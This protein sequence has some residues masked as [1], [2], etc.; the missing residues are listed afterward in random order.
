MLGALASCRVR[1]EGILREF[2][3]TTKPCTRTLS[4]DAGSLRLLRIAASTGMIA[5]REGGGMA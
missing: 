1:V 2:G 5:E 4:C 3:R